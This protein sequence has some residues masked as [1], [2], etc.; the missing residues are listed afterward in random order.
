M[1]NVYLEK[2]HLCKLES[3]FNISVP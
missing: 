3:Y 1:K 2:S